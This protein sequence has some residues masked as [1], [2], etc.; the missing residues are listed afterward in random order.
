MSA[1]REAWGRDAGRLNTATADLDPPLAVADLDAFDANAADLVRRARGKPI[2]VASKSVRCR[3][4]LEDVLAKEDRRFVTSDVILHGELSQRNRRIFDA[5]AWLS[6]IGLFVVLGLLASPS[7][8]AD[9][10][11]PSEFA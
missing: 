4:L 6:Q 8:L 2:R 3:S 9:A 5:L 11:V 7:R 10:L 1:V